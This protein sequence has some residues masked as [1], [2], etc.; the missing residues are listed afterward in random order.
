MWDGYKGIYFDS[1]E[2]SANGAYGNDSDATDNQWR[3]F[4]SSWS[5][6]Q[7]QVDGHFYNNQ[8]IVWYYQGSL[9]NPLSNNYCPYFYNPNAI[10][11]IG[12]ATSNGCP[13]TLIA[14][15][16]PE[17]YE[18]EQGIAKNYVRNIIQ[19]ADSFYSTDY[20]NNFYKDVQ[21]AYRVLMQNYDDFIVEDAD[22]VIRNWKDS[23]LLTNIGLIQSLKDHIS[24]DEFDDA[25]EDL[26][27]VTNENILTEN[28]Q[29]A[30]NYYLNYILP[31]DSLDS[32]SCYSALVDMA[33][34]DAAIGGE[35]V[36]MARAMLRLDIF[37]IASLARIAAPKNIHTSDENSIQLFPNP[38]HGECVVKFKLNEYSSLE[39]YD[40]KGQ[41]L[42]NILLPDGSNNKVLDFSGFES[43][44]YLIKLKGINNAI[45]SCKLIIMN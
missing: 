23:L 13:D 10:A 6:D 45:K 2:F 5:S 11:P 30:Y 34:S 16:S 31:E 26:N 39:I 42:K 18:N 20:R 43:G 32:N 36:Y 41:T 12:N 44:T 1:A 29:K 9:L 7:L 35:G 27:N 24:Y 15:L 38:L 21:S 17:E 3:E 19:N 25:S 37:D 33:H 8:V 40:L 4:R 22:S 28:Q 14:P